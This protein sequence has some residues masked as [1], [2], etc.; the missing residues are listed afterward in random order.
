MTEVLAICVIQQIEVMEFALK[1][2]R[3][4]SKTKE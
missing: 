2:H 3:G 4:E 1:T